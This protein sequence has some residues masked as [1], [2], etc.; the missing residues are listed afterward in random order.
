MEHPVNEIISSFLPFPITFRPCSSCASMTSINN[1][2]VSPQ[3]PQFIILGLQKW[4]SIVIKIYSTY[5][6]E[7]TGVICVLKYY[8]LLNLPDSLAGLWKLVNNYMNINNN[9]P[10]SAR[11]FFPFPEIDFEDKQ[12]VSQETL[13]RCAQV[14]L[15][16]FF[17]RALEDL[18]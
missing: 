17:V 7:V 5:Q 14:Y 18:L 15:F 3:L 8:K 13:S 16:S 6:A 9:S 12:Q 4:S 1:T 11:T 10:S 2:S